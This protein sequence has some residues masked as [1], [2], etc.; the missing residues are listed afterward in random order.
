MPHV[1]LHCQ[2]AK[3][4]RVIKS[5]DETNQNGRLGAAESAAEKQKLAMAHEP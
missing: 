3:Q 4:V 5:T 2:S 1:V